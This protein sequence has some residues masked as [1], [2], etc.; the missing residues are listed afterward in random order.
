MWLWRRSL[1]PTPRCPNPFVVVSL[2]RLYGYRRERAAAQDGPARPFQVPEFAAGLVRPRGPAT[3]V[4]DKKR[5]TYPDDVI[6]YAY[7]VEP[8]AAM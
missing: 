2:S 3:G 7:G 4:R 1:P 5:R 8:R 6:V